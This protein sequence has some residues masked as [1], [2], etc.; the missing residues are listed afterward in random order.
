MML[1]DDE[2]ERVVR[3]ADPLRDRAPGGFDEQAAV[4]TLGRA[5]R[6]ARRSRAR[7]LMVVPVVALAV[8]GATAGTY[9]WIAGDG[10]GHAIDTTSVTCVGGV[11]GDAIIGF[12]AAMED[13][14]ILCKGGWKDMFGSPPPPRLTA[15]VDSSRQ[16]S[17]KVYEGGR[18]QCARHRSD[19]YGGPTAE[20]R[21]LALFRADLKARFADRGC[22]SF[23]ATA[24]LV[25][26]L[27]AKH[28]LAGWT[29]RQ[30]QTADKEKPGPCAEI[31]Y[32]DQTRKTVWLGDRDPGADINYV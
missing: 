27:L 28:D 9:R 3:D 25:K 14:V 24:A 8:A 15:C 30:F 6:Q 21:H 13:P 16:G 29:T 7:R 23:P 19:P 4:A 32:Y 26:E 2:F 1:G 11:G 12:D 17:V 5:R 10:Q 22:T 31:S 20:Q 18:E